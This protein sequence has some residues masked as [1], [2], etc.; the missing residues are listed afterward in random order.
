MIHRSPLLAL[1]AVLTAIGSLAGAVNAQ[2]TP[3]AQSI[4]ANLVP[5]TSAVLLFAL[6][7]R[8]VQIYACETDPEDATA[9]VWTF[10]APR[11]SYSMPMARLSAATSPVP[12]GRVRTAA[13]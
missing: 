2:G 12:P 4:P 6:E 9:F 11:P 10:Q 5:P 13:P 8:G 3:A 1:I 7:A